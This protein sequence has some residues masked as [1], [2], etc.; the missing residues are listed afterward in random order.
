MTPTTWLDRAVGYIAPQRGLKRIRARVA[1]DL[2]IRHYEAASTGRRTQGWRRTSGDAN[3]DVAPSLT[4]LRELARDLVRNNPH[5]DNAL[6][7]I[8]NQTVGD[9]IMA[10]PFPFGKAA[11]DAWKAWAGT[12]ACDADGRH[13]FYGLQKLV[14]RSV[15]ESGEVLVRR[16]FRLPA[17]GLPLPFQIQLLEPDY[18][19]TAKSGVQ[20]PNKGRIIHGVEFDAL[21]RRAAYWLFREH[22][23]SRTP[24]TTAGPGA[25]T[26]VPAED[27]LHIF[28]Q[29][30]VGQIRAATWFASSL[31]KSK[32]F[33]EYDD[34][35]LMKQKIAACL[36]VLTSDVDGTG[37]PLGTVDDTTAQPQ[38]DSLEPGM[39]MNVP[40]G[41][42]ISVVDPPSVAEFKDYASVTLHAIAVGIGLTHEDFTGDYQ[43]LPFSAARMS[44]LAHQSRLTDWRWRT[45]IPQFC[46]P[47]WGWAMEAAV[48]M[49]QVRDPAPSATWTAPAVPFIDPSAEGL[50]FQRNIRGGLQTWSESVR[51]RGYDPDEVLIE[52]ASD[53]Q[54]FDDLGIILDSDPRKTTQ[55][56]LPRDNQQQQAAPQPQEQP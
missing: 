56:G 27:V 33:D 21:G 11:A 2:L 4:R 30:R 7:T 50:A 15:A 39:I 52:M 12:T 13:D 32:D 25:S 8:A 31:L 48:I 10:K 19:D 20:L 3:A 14:M 18:L 34:A 38:I 49:G 41:R 37:A 17:D 23:G 42:S 5:A 6:D 35:Q 46:Q 29:E 9:G 43:N 24:I 45:L 1:A 51:E 53:N 47:V 16:R 44:R 40:P 28:H 26:R 54:K 55:A 22:P 36:A